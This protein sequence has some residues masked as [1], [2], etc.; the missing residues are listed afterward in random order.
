VFERPGHAGGEAHGAAPGGEE[1][2]GASPGPTLEGAL[3][4]LGG[5]LGELGGVLRG[6]CE[7]HAG[8]G[9]GAVAVVCHVDED[10]G[11]VRASTVA[12]G[13]LGALAGGERGP[14]RARAGGGG[15]GQRGQGPAEIS[16]SAAAAI[17]E[18]L[19]TGI[20]N[21][22]QALADLEGGAGGG[23]GEGGGA[24]G[25]RMSAFAHLA[26]A[27]SLL[28]SM[29]YALGQGDGEGGRGGGGVGGDG[30]P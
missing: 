8:V 22:Y 13:A 9:M 19:E 14:K 25:G 10:S 29:G 4:E 2:Q 27:S 7:A 21:A 18:R 15:G 3:G 5:A 12:A 1:G 16:D 28:V 23:R 30:P 17:R 24:E 11:E 6:M 20:R 26:V